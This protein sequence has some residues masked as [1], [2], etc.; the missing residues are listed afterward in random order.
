[1]IASN[2]AQ[3]T[4][5][6]T[7]ND[8]SEKT[9]N[10]KRNRALINESKNMTVQKNKRIR[11]PI[12]SREDS[13]ANQLSPIPVAVKRKNFW[14]MTAGIILIVM[15]ASG[16]WWIS[17]WPN[18]S[19]QYISISQKPTGSGIW[20][21]LEKEF[22]ANDIYGKYQTENNG[23]VL[24]MTLNENGEVWLN[25]TPQTEMTSEKT[26]QYDGNWYLVESK[27]VELEMPLVE[28]WQ[29]SRWQAEI[30]NN[31]TTLTNSD[32]ALTFRKL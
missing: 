12:I 23:Q 17:T 25:I 9:E 4:S 27:V 21:N 30:K 24:T 5:I 3:R 26:I 1:M 19:A 31:Q 20:A 14:A 6:H 16:Y 15:I 32:L 10:S 7:T 11:R 28:N 18:T 29:K 8:S 22:N 2:F 13:S